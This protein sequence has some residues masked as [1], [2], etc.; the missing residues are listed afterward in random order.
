MKLS[1]HIDLFFDGNKSAF[2]KSM[3][4]TPQQVTIWVNNDWVIVD[5]T[6]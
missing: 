6:L 4:V 1:E 3:N 2:V 5:R